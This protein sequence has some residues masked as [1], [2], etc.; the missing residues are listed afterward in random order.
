VIEIERSTKHASLG[1][2]V[3]TSRTQQGIATAAGRLAAAAAFEALHFPSLQIYTN[4]ENIASRRVADKIGAKLVQ[5]K[6][7]EDGVFCAVYEL[8]PEDLS[9]ETFNSPGNRIPPAAD[10]ADGY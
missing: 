8:K 1:W 3:R 5:I 4:T 7:E 10:L 2:W 6:A 9:Q